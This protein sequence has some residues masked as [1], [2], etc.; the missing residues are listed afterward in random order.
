MSVMTADDDDDEDDD[1]SNYA[2]WLRRL[3]CEVERFYPDLIYVYLDD[4]EE[5]WQLVRL[6]YAAVNDIPW[7]CLL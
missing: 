2:N 1:E 6:H 3:L 4:T 5:R 7:I